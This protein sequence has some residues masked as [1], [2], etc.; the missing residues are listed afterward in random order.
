MDIIR[1]TSFYATQF[2]H[3]TLKRQAE[4]QF[5]FAS[6]WLN[7]VR[8]KKASTRSKYSIAIPMWLIPGIHF[9]RHICSLHFSTQVSNEFFDG[10]YQNMTKTMNH[11]HHP[12]HS[13][14]P[15]MQPIRPRTPV[16]NSSK[17]RRNRRAVRL[18]R[19]EQLDQMDR[20][21]DRRRAID[22]L[23]GHIKMVTKTSFISKKM[24]EDLA[25]LKIRNFHKISLLA[26]GQFATSE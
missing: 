25:S 2:E 11:L 9:L 23:I 18:T 26:R 22:G 7:F 13:S 6:I 24:E 12:V 3:E 20:R 15:S 4:R 17:P 5:A 1:E 21:I 8:R 10:F 14:V 16:H 19:I